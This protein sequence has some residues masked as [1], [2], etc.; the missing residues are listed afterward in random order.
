MTLS[1]PQ[2]ATQSPFFCL[3]C[4]A[5]DNQALAI[6]QSFGVNIVACAGCGFV[7][8]EYVG[9]AT[10]R[11]FYAHS[12]RPPMSAADLAAERSKQTTQADGQIRYLLTHAPGLKVARALDFGGADGALG[13]ALRRFADHVD[14]AEYDP[15]F[16]AVLRQD[17]QVE[18]ID[19]AA[20]RRPD[21]VGTYGLITISHVL[22]HQPDPLALLDVFAALLGTDGLLLIDVPNEADLVARGFQG[23]GHLSYFSPNSLDRLMAVHGRFDKI[24]LRTCNNEQTDFI[25]SGFR[26][27]ESYERDRAE[28]GMTIRSLWRRRPGP[29]P[30]LTQPPER[31]NRPALLDLYSLRLLYMFNRFNE[32]ASRARQLEAENAALKRGAP[33]PD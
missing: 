27:E 22:E 9:D 18:F 5:S 33:I 1:V 17:P 29:A 23:R 8:S 28:N 30:E 3:I 16:A 11:Q 7:Q 14:V 2:S 6:N 15:Q 10:L 19:P 32:V 20:L 31:F 13:R 21:L 4:G 24:E 12:Y 25:A 26:L